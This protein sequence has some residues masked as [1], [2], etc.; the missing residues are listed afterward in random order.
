MGKAGGIIAIISGVLGILAGFATLFMGG[1][2]GAFE[3]SG[4]A[5]VVAYG[6][7]G[8]AASMPVIAGG[9]VALAKPRAGGCVIVAFSLLG[10]VLGGT[11]VAICL[12]LALAGGILAV[13]AKSPV[14]TPDEQ[15]PTRKRWQALAGSIMAGIILSVAGITVMDKKDNPT[16]S[17]P[18]AHESAAPD[19]LAVEA[20]AVGEQFEVTLHAFEVY[21]SLGSGAFQKRAAP[22]TAFVVLDITVKCIDRESRWYTPGDLVAVL[23]GREFSFDKHETIIGVTRMF[24]QINPLTTDRG[25]LVFQVPAEALQGQ[26]AWHPG[27]GFGTVRFTLAPRAAAAPAAQPSVTPSPAGAGVEVYRNG[28]STLKLSAMAGNLIRFKLVAVGEAGNTGE[29]E[30]III[31]A[32]GAASWSDDETH[33]E[34]S[35]RQSGETIAVTQTGTCDFAARVTA[36]GEYRFSP[37]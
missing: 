4:A 37:Q 19:A 13:L 30:G 18:A 2:G 11:L 32:N 7:I 36:D 24:G 1:L 10:I 16:P 12:V 31:P 9:G 35:F 17:E 27:R 25:V 23:D 21:Q 20:T 5:D 28:N 22:G 26:L 14:A 33:C 8:I 29:A 15:E 3:A 6:W 34:L